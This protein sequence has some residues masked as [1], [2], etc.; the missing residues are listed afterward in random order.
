MFLSRH[1]SAVLFTFLTVAVLAAE[2]SGQPR[3]LSNDDVK[4]VLQSVSSPSVIP[5]K[6]KLRKELLAMRDE[7]QKVDSRIA[8]DLEKN[9]S[10]IPESKSI[11]EKHM[12]RV[13]QIVR[14]NGW[15]TKD[16]IGDDGVAA[17]TDLIRNNEL[18]TE[19]RELLPVLIEAANKGYIAKSIVAS[20]IDSI[21]LALG[22]PQIFGTQARIRNGIIYLLP[23]LDEA[24][25]EEWRKA[26]DLPSLAVEIRNLED[27]Y[28]MP[29]LRVPL[30]RA[31]A[32]NGKTNDISGLGISTDESEPVKVETKIVNLNVRIV[33]RDF[34]AP[35]QLNLTK[36]DFSIAEDGVAQ[37]VAFFSTAEKPFDLI[38]ILDFSGSTAEKR[39]LIKKAARRFVEYARPQDRVAIVAFGDE[40]KMISDL[41]EDKTAMAEKI[42]EINISGVSPIWDSMNFAFKIIID[43]GSLGRRSA[44]VIMTDGLDGSRESTF[45]DLMEAT[46][47]RETTIYPVYLDLEKNGVA[48]FERLRRKAQLSLSMLADES[49]GQ[50]YKVDDLKDLNGIYEQVVNDLGKVYSVGY[51]PK[52]EE[53][54]GGWRSLTVM[55]KTQT[56]LIA[57]TRR[58]YYAN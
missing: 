10:L 3:C 1:F 49:G 35:T 5:D 43:K 27:R 19:Q 39:G 56:N 11:A 46:R 26:Y 50:L 41:T 13:C 40:I 37:Q 29:L 22:S 17:L 47:R 30:P 14:E 34:K 6:K 48:W 21:R 2:L 53:R 28:A 9:Q 52:N 7:L 58:G 45:A 25:V 20:S 16:S 38:L 24:K 33:T 8:F 4:R 31:L 42:K 32:M 57:K 12:L 44:I 51:E 18:Y 23:L 55:L 36:D 54:D 15:L